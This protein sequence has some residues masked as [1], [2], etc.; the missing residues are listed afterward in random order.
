MEMVKW[1]SMVL[2]ITI[3]QENKCQE[4]EAAA[5]PD[6]INTGT[7]PCRSKHEDGEFHEESGVEG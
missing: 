5:A 1:E 7:W 6:K 3:Q 2:R 4:V